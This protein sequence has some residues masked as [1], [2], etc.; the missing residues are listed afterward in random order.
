MKRMKYMALYALLA[1]SA[2]DVRAAMVDQYD[3]VN[4]VMVADQ[5]VACFSDI[6]GYAWTSDADV[7]LQR[8]LASGAI[9]IHPALQKLVGGS[10]APTI[11]D[12][13]MDRLYLSM[14][15]GGG[16]HRLFDGGHTLTGAW[17]RVAAASPNDSVMQEAI[18]YIK[19]LTKDISTPKGLP[20]ATWNRAVYNRAA[21]FAARFGIPKEY[22]AKGVSMTADDLLSSGI[23][24][25]FIALHWNSGDAKMFTR[26]VSS[27]GVIAIAQANPLLAAVVLIATVRAFQIAVENDQYADAVVGALQGVIGTGS[28][29]A[30]AVIVTAAISGPIGVVMSI[31]AAVAVGLLVDTAIDWIAGSIAQYNQSIVSIHTAD[32]SA[33][34]QPWSHA[35]VQWTHAGVQWI[36]ALGATGQAV[37]PAAIPKGADGLW[38]RAK[39]QYGY[40]LDATSTA[41]GAT[42]YAISD[43]AG[44]ASDATM[45]LGKEVLEWSGSVMERISR[46]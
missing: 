24:G 41:I 9:S 10:A 11:Y 25:V 16:N 45:E 46:K 17:R 1:L 31:T 44:K 27:A 6:D 40:A 38:S 7:A 43:S 12:K 29:I 36:D 37:L 2:V 26:L 39:D 33:I 32:V 23:S 22:F 35:G 42:G 18:G 30:A 19:A 21:E 15:Q 8:A 3:F 28:A 13:A 14:R 4:Q 5:V 34:N 20:I